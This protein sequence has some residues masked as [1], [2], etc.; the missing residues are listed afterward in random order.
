MTSASV[1]VGPLLRADAERC[2]ELEEL[3]FPGDDPWS[4][5]AFRDEIGA[6]HVYVGVR[7]EGTLIGYA[8]LAFTAG[9]PQPEAEVHTIGVDP[10]HQ[11]RGLGR[12]LLHRLLTPADE[13][14]ATIFLEVRTD[15]EPARRLYESEGFEIVGVRKRYYRPS[16]A[17]A[18]TMRRDARA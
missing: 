5:Q 14:G 11:G 2:A 4:A 13:V 15:N 16:G 1:V 12:V 10:A 8:G 3:L 7:S 18:Y 17:D 9:P 6:G